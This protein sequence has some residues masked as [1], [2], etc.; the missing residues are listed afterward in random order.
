MRRATQLRCDPGLHGNISIHAL[1]AES[2]AGCMRMAHTAMDFY[3]RSPCGERLRKHLIPCQAGQ[4]LSTLSLRRA[5]RMICRQTM[6]TAAI[7]IHALLAESDPLH[8]AVL[9]IIA[10]SIHALLAES[11][12]MATVY[13]QPPGISIH[14]LLAESDMILCDLPYGTTRFLSTLSLRRAT[15]PI[16]DSWGIASYFY[17]RSPCGERPANT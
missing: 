8:L 17:P 16:S 13:I 9:R 4:F 7:S 15:L 1:L 3:P 10:I 12:I 14:A 6:T 5:T 2:D 11:D